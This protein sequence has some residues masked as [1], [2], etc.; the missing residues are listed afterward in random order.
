VWAYDTNDISPSVKEK[1]DHNQRSNSFALTKKTIVQ[2]GDIM[3]E[4]INEVK[5]GGVQ[6]IDHVK[7]LLGVVA[8]NVQGVHLSKASKIMHPCMVFHYINDGLGN[9]NALDEGLT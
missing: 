4:I 1:K 3:Q 9:L 8:T 6:F 2:L 5:E 7:S